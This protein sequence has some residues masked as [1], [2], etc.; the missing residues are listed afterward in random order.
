M[1]IDRKI[2]VMVL[3]GMEFQLLQMFM[4]KG[5]CKNLNSIIEKQGGQLHSNK[6]PYESSAM[7]TAFTGYP[8][9]DHG[10]FSCWNVHNYEYVPKVL[11]SGDLDKK[12]IWQMDEFADKKFAVIN[13]LGTHKPYKING[14][15]LTYLFEQ[16]LHACYPDN[17]IRDLSKK[18]FGCGHDVSAFYHGEER[19]KFLEKVFKID[20]LRADIGLELLKDVDIEIVNF[21]LLD[22]IS[23]YYW[24]ELSS[25]VFASVEE[26]ALFKGYN[27]IDEIVGRYLD[28]LNNESDLFIFSDY[29]FGELREFVSI[30]KYLKQ[31]GFLKY[32]EDGTVDW[33]KT[34][35]FESVQGSHGVNINLVGRYANGIVKK[36]DYNTVREQVMQCLKEIINPKTG[37][38]YCKEVLCGEDYYPG[39]NSSKAP[40]IMMEPMDYRYLPLG[41]QFWSKHVFRNY[42]SGWHRRNAFWTGVGKNFNNCKADCSILDVTPTIFSLAGKKVP[43][44]LK[45]KSIL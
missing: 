30:N 21:T 35:A 32:K 10:V 23:H 14:Y 33:S 8:E 38:H 4:Q 17:L 45:G 3:E 18:G 40:D 22:R 39:V 1:S 6:V 12:F 28:V 31:A 37:M 19:E 5:Y 16:S 36:E 15:M 41:D 27:F 2:I 42:Q 29:G 44:F 34:I 26:T 20:N 24:Q 7:Q 9:G 43:D 13:I 25:D 11:D